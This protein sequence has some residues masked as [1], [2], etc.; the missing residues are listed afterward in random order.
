MT[1]IASD[2]TATVNLSSAIADKPP[3]PTSMPSHTRERSSSRAF[4]LTQSPSHPSSNPHHNTNASAR[5]SIGGQPEP[6]LAV[7]KDT[8]SKSQKQMTKAERRELQERQRA[9]KA[10]EKAAGTLSAKSQVSGKGAPQAKP[11]KAA[12]GK[13]NKSAD[14]KPNKSADGKPA[15]G[16]QKEAPHSHVHALMEETARGI[17][18]FSHFG[19]PK[20]PTATKGDIHPAIIP[21]GLRFSEFEVTGANARCI[22]MLTAFKSVSLQWPMIV[23]W[24][25]TLHA[26]R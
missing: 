10:T 23:F 18:I 1:Y 7:D 17:R 9:A 21:L 22:A 4:L 19:L 3:A 11:S 16:D 14:G 12:D 25:L 5:T 13:P 20:P 26:P 24:L 6:N 15:K 2:P 8:V